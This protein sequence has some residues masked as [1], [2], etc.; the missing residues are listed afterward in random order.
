MLA[1][2]GDRGAV[3]EL[4]WHHIFHTGEKMPATDEV[5]TPEEWCTQLGWRIIDPAGW[6]GLD[7]RDMADKIGK[8]EFISRAMAS[9][10]E[11]LPPRNNDEAAE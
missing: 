7:G 6:R 9:T 3:T 10:V 2:P 5:H 8:D 1:G 11:K 4:P